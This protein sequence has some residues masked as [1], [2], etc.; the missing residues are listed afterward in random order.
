MSQSSTRPLISMIIPCYNVIE[1]LPCLMESL[2]D[3][4]DSAI[5]II[6][7]DDG[8]IDGTAN[9]I[10]R[11]EQS[12]IYPNVKSLLLQKNEGQSV[13]RNKGIEL[14]IGEYIWFVDSDDL[15]D[16]E[17][18]L[19]I[20]SCLKRYKPDVLFT[21]LQTFCN[22]DKPCKINQIAKSNLNKPQT[23]SFTK[24][25]LILTNADTILFY[26]FQDS[27]MHPCTSIL[28]RECLYNVRF[29]EGRKLEDVVAMP[30]MVANA[31]S[32]YY[33]PKPAVHY[34][35]REGST[36]GS[37]NLQ[38]FLDYSSAMESVTD[39]FDSLGIKEQT[40]MQMFLCYSKILRWSLND[41]IKFNLL[42]KETWKTYQENLNTFYEKLNL[43]A[44]GFFIANLGNDRLK[45]V[46]AASV[47]IA[48]PKL[49]AL[50]RS[51]KIKWLFR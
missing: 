15:V 14:S 7:I 11:L 39:Y 35:L 33:L 37:A 51:K 31:K 49:Y 8:S 1:F 28:K 45:N 27:K 24:N 44:L 23:R 26:Y 18:A 34:R 22:K 47:F 17:V 20:I 5:E 2:K 13:A 36:M 12:K 6:L 30:K 46:L 41:I 43:S 48:L 4:L 38:T 19:E 21:D 50:L 3:I 10:H 16:T 9:F 42:T 25:S 32:Y 29:P 40:R